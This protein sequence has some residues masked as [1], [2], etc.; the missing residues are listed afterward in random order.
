[1]FLACGAY[2]RCQTGSSPS[3]EGAP[4]KDEREAAETQSHT[5]NGHAP[6]SACIVFDFG[7]ILVGDESMGRVWTLDISSHQSSKSILMSEASL[8][9]TQQMVCGINKRN[10]WKSYRT[11]ETILKPLL[12]EEVPERLEKTELSPGVVTA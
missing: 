3:L 6:I 11:K 8:E 2:S 10:P 9:R 4:Q 12:P 1:M 5:E 7:M